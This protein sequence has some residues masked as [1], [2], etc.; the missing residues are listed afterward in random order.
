MDKYK[1]ITVLPI[2]INELLPYFTFFCSQVL[3]GDVDRKTQFVELKQGDQGNNCDFFVV[4]KRHITVYT[5]TFS[6]FICMNCKKTTCNETIM[7]FLMANL[8]HMNESSETKLKVTAYLCSDLYRIEDF[9][10]VSTHGEFIASRTLKLPWQHH[11]S[12]SEIN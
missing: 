4:N 8:K 6:Q 10:N 3:R 12:F 2:S 5:R 9:K 7:V 1:Q 11:L